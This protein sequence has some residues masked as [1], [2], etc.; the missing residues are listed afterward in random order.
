MRY[1]GLIDRGSLHL[2]NYQ[3]LQIGLFL[4]DR[5]FIQMQVRLLSAVIASDDD[6]VGHSKNWN[7]IHGW[8]H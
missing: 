3:L 8:T 4:D 5:L 1:V 7:I 6:I 2:Y